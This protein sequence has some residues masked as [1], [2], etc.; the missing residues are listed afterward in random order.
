MSP[1]KA[2]G[3][4]CHTHDAG[5]DLLISSLPWIRSDDLF[6]NASSESIRDWPLGPHG[7]KV[8]VKVKIAQLCPTLCDLMD[9]TV[10]G[11]LQARILEWVAF[12]FSRGIF[13][14]QGLNPGVPHCREI[15]SQLSHKG[16]PRI[17]EWVAYP[18]SSGYSRARNQTRVSYITGGFFTN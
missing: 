11:I 12:P 7:R 8:K 9:Y 2:V 13:L 3:H 10:H 15:L 6:C 1:I 17:L 14:T 18:F 4:R 5:S 16:S